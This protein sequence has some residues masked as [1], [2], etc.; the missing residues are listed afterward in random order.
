MKTKI[1]DYFFLSLLPFLD[2]FSTNS[3]FCINSCWKQLFYK[4][5][6]TNILHNK[7]EINILYNEKIKPVSVVCIMQKGVIDISM[8]K[9]LISLC[10][11][12][13]IYSPYDA[14]NSDNNNYTREILDK[15]P[16][17][18]ILNL[19]MDS[20]RMSSAFAYDQYIQTI[21]NKLHK[22]TILNFILNNSSPKSIF[23]E[24][25]HKLIHVQ[26][27]Q[28]DFTINLNSIINC[29]KLR[30]LHFTDNQFSSRSIHNVINILSQLKSQLT[31]FHFVIDSYKHD[32]D[33]SDDDDYLHPLINSVGNIEYIDYKSDEDVPSLECIHYD[34]DVPPLVSVNSDEDVP[35]LESVHFMQIQE[36]SDTKD[37]IHTISNMECLTEL[38]FNV[39]K[40]ESSA[41]YHELFQHLPKSL[42]SLYITSRCTSILNPKVFTYSSTP[43]KNLYMINYHYQ[44]RQEVTLFHIIFPQLRCLS[45]Q[46]YH[47]KDNPMHLSYNPMYLSYKSIP[48]LNQLMD[49]FKYLQSIDFQC[50]S[51][52]TQKLPIQEFKDIIATIVDRTMLSTKM[53]KQSINN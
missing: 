18:K 17:I 20:P 34:E 40:F 38:H 48:Y 44:L 7:F 30:T 3:V 52:I 6:D 31:T 49:G 25:R 28:S 29:T 10:S 35:P 46:N 11:Q 51:S 42:H 15:L 41:I 32:D 36:F 37:L 24:N 13:E 26:S 33:D 19:R 5:A 22:H 14:F 1:E 47:T 39:S 27:F 12:V 8:Y 43:I 16:Y 2:I 23:T 45:I 53:Q 21:Q 50:H 9:G 4:H